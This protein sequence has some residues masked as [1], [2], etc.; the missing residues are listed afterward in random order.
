MTRAR[1]DGLTD[2]ARRV[3]AEWHRIRAEC[4]P[5]LGS[6]VGMAPLSQAVD[7]LQEALDDCTDIAALAEDE[8]E[9]GVT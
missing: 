9:I 3:V 6:A 2:A 4:R 8:P 7:A 1:P 5:G